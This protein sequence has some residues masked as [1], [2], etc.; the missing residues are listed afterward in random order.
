MQWENRCLKL[1]INLTPDLEV[2]RETLHT[3]PAK[4]SHFQDQTGKKMLKN[5]F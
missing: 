2:Y 1:K 5:A 3:L 4:T